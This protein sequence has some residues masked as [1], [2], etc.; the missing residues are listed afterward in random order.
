[1]RCLIKETLSGI[2]LPIENSLNENDLSVLFTRL[3]FQ[4]VF[5]NRLSTSVTASSVIRRPESDHRDDRCTTHP[6]YHRSWCTTH[7]AAIT[8]GRQENTAGRQGNT[9]PDCSRA[10][11]RGKTL[12]VMKR[13]RRKQGVQPLTNTSLYNSW[14]VWGYQH[15]DTFCTCRGSRWAK[16]GTSRNKGKLFTCL[17]KVQ[18]G[19]S[20]LPPPHSISP[21]LSLPSSS[22]TCYPF[23]T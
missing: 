12:K 2:S 15:Q 17:L 21:S 6:D 8:A 19:C 18:D 13:R 20:I 1:M 7:A 16:Q 10:C 23:H 14:E 4:Y 5:Q 22:T 3:T 11:E 9:L